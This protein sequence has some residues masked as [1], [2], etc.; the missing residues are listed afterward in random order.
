[1]A[2]NWHRI[3]RRDRYQWLTCGLFADSKPMEFKIITESDLDEIGT[4]C[5]DNDCGRRMSFD[6]FRFDNELQ[7]TAFLLRWG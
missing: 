7:V 6:Q 2:L 3:T 1:M 4:W 5:R